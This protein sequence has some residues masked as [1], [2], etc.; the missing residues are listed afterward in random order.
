MRRKCKVLQTP[1]GGLSCS[2]PGAYLPIIFFSNDFLRLPPISELHIWKAFKGLMPTTYITLSGTNGFIMKAYFTIFA[3][4][5][6]YIFDLSLSRQHFP[7][8]WK[9]KCLM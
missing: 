5:L 1:T 2:S 9:K 8:Q 6:K 4:L 7:K 3:P